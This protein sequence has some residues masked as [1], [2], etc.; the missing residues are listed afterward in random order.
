MR[1]FSFMDEHE[2]DKIYR[3]VRPKRPSTVIKRAL[4]ELDVSQSDL[5]KAIG[6]SKPYI[7]LLLQGDRQLGENTALCIEQALG[8][9]AAE[10]M[11]IQVEYNFWRAVKKN[12]DR[13]LSVPSLG[14]AKVLVAK[15]DAL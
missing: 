7:C 4:K 12:K 6:V 8:I 9:N 11:Q 5:A 13:Y 2:I 15:A 10:L 3:K 14:K 1:G